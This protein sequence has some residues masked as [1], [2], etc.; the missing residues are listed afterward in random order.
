MVSCVKKEFCCLCMPLWIGVCITG[1]IVM[2]ECL[3]FLIAT[4]SRE[5]SQI[6]FAIIFGLKLLLA[7]LFIWMAVQSKNLTA[8]KAVFIGFI[9]E[10][11]LQVLV[12]IT[13][14]VIIS[15]TYM[16]HDS[17]E[18]ADEGEWTWVEEEDESFFESIDECSGAIK[19]STTIYTLIFF[20]AY[21]PFRIWMAWNLR[22]FMDLLKESKENEDKEQ[23]PQTEPDTAINGNGNKV[24]ITDENREEEV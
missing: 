12:L 7:L 3:Y 16:N 13:L 18:E 17:C 8:R 2:C 10:M 5:K 14:L 11:L 6:N 1:G 19:I 21:L 9:A 23:I 20:L 24:H 22:D 15:V 4:F